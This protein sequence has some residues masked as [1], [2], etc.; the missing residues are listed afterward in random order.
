MN[1]QKT[2]TG[3]GLRLLLLTGMNKVWEREAAPSCRK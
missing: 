1:Q 2:N 3:Y